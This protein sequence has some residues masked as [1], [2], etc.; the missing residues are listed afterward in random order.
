M[1]AENLPG[2][3]QEAFGVLR[4]QRMP[5]VRI[6]AISGNWVYV[7]LPTL[8]FDPRVY[9]EPNE[10][11]VWVRLPDAFPLANPHGMVTPD[12]LNPRD[13]HPVKGHNPGHE[14]CKPVESL[15]GKHYYS[16]TWAG[17]LGPGAQL[18]TPSD[19]LGVVSWLERRI[20]MA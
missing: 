5:G 7:W 15:G 9:P 6:D 19:I 13:G 20:R 3:F 16:W 12:A 14:M 11:G 4:E 2:P 1:G 17:E 8:R 10:R 18:A